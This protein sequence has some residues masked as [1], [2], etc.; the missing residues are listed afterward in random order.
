MA[1]KF[2][3]VHDACWAAAVKAHGDTAGTTALTEALL[4]APTSRTSTWSPI[5]RLPYRLRF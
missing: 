5:L 1:A 4:L 3:L 2:T